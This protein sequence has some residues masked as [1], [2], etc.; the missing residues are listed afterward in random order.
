MKLIDLG[1]CVGKLEI[2]KQGFSILTILSAVSNEDGVFF[3][4]SSIEICGDINLIALRDA[5]IAAFPFPQEAAQPD[6][7]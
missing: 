5:L 2:K 6:H 7:D 1:Y 3:P 4:A